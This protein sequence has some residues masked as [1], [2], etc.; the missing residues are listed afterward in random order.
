MST[1]KVDNLDT[2]TGTGNIT[3]NRPLVGDGSGLTNLPSQ[4]A[5]DFTN[6][7]KT[8]LDNV[9]ASATADQTKTDIEG[10]GIELPA[11]NLTGTI[12]EAR[13]PATALNSNVSVPTEITKSTSEPAIDTNPSGGVGTV[14]L[15]TTTGV[16]YCCTDATTDENVWTNVGA[17]SGDI[18]PWGRPWGGTAYGYQAG[19]YDGSNSNVIDKFSFTTDGNAT[20][21]GDLTWSTDGNACHSST[22]YGYCA[23]GDHPVTTNIN[24]WS[25][26]SDGNAV[27]YG[28]AVVAGGWGTSGSY[29]TT[30]G[31]TWGRNN[32]GPYHNLIDKFSFE[33]EA[34]ATD[35]GDM[36]VAGSYTGASSTETYGYCMGGGPGTHDN[37]IDR[38]SFTTDG[39][40]TDVGDL[41]AN[42]ASLS[43]HQSSTH[44]YASGGSGGSGNV[45]QKYAF[46][47]SSNSTDVGDLLAVSQD[48]SGSSSTA[49]GYHAC[50]H[51]SGTNT[52]TIQ[53]FSTSSDANATDV[54]NMTVSCRYTGGC[55]Y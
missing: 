26:A 27:A 35:V 37:V 20:D 38:V 44:G 2:R 53:K 18:L 24:K 19:G 15:R 52:D 11:A 49:Y 51:E 23:T 8:K 54:G 40:A 31:Y 45:I 55:Q 6:T 21:V 5:N 4:T 46:G 47:S 9:E 14:W 3:L 48:G 10:L 30:H 32:S 33:T 16:M 39:N 17:G 22:T 12:A 41:L 25:F 42:T 13:I 1:I 43:G 50:G 29:S 7:L 36:S 28:G 34:N